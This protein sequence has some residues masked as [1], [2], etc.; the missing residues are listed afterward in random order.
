LVSTT[1]DPRKVAAGKA[2]MRA[3]WGPDPRIVRLDTLPAAHRAA[4]LAY[5]AVARA[6][7]Q[8][9]PGVETGSAEAEGHGNDRPAA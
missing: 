2:G 3:R 9:D 7:E 4:I 5:L 8:A 1:K 6:N